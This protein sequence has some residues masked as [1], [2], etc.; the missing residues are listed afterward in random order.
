M[1]YMMRRVDAARYAY[2]SRK[3]REAPRARDIF[4]AARAMPLPL[5]CRYAYAAFHTRYAAERLRD[6]DYLMPPRLMP[7]DFTFHVT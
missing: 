2:K 5:R 4:H 1:R 6:D 7:R 3:R